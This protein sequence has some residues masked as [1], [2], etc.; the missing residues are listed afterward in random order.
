M[1]E[2][3]DVIN[4]AVVP[5]VGVVCSREQE[6]GRVIDSWQG[7]VLCSVEGA[8]DKLEGTSLVL[9]FDGACD[10]EVGPHEHLKL[11][12]LGLGDLISVGRGGD[13]WLSQHIC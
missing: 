6:M 10:G 8:E 13:V 2:N 4:T 7:V 5:L 1:E 11:L 9:R 3:I 12:L